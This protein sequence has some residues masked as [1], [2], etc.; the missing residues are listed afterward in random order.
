MFQQLKLAG[1]YSAG[2]AFHG[3]VESGVVVFY[4]VYV[5][6][7]LYI[8]GQFFPDLTLKGNLGAFSW[9]H[10]AAGELPAVLE[11]A[12]APLGGKY[13]VVPDNDGCYYMDGLHMGEV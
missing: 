1:E 3:K 12:V 13:L 10:L 5:V 7:N 2:I 6:A 4:C 9:L 8:C 11:F